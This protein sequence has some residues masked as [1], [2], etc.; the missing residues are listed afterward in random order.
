MGTRIAISD[1]PLADLGS[2]NQIQSVPIATKNDAGATIAQRSTIAEM[3]DY[4]REGARPFRPLS[5]EFRVD[6]TGIVQFPLPPQIAPGQRA[7]QARVPFSQD[8]LTIFNGTE[9][10]FFVTGDRP[11]IQTPGLYFVIISINGRYQVAA[12]P[13]GHRWQFETLVSG[14]IGVISNAGTPMLPSANNVPIDVTLA[15]TA[16]LFQV[17]GPVNVAVFIIPHN[18]GS[19]ITPISI[20]ETFT[21]IG[22]SGA[23]TTKL[24]FIKLSELQE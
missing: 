9:A 3:A 8:Q 24:E 12:Q 1:A 21:L 7:G 11:V 18:T 16:G 6:P 15:V 23:I 20:Q 14:G 19:V 17:T 4:F 5:A 10:D 22:G 2:P 13:E